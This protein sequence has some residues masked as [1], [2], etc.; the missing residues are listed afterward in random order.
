MKKLT[1]AAA[2]TALAVLAVPAVAS[3][4]PVFT[5]SNG[6]EI[7]TITA[8]QLASDPVIMETPIGNW[9]CEAVDLHLN[10]TTPVTGQSQGSGTGET[11]NCIDEPLGIPLPYTEVTVSNL[12]LSGGS[13][14]AEITFKYDFANFAECH[15][16]GTVNFS[17]VS[18]TDVI[19][20]NKGNELTGKQLGGA[21]ICPREGTTHGSFTIEDVNGKPITTH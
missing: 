18:T 2:A 19:T 5:D 12:T 10:V 7:H 17:Y 14:S 11:T 6:K 21:E 8:T 20:I 3:A 13:G 4:T 1:L 9:E 16:E 15:F